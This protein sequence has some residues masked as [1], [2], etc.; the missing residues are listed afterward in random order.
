MGSIWVCFPIDS[1]WRRKE[2]NEMNVEHN[3]LKNC[4]LVIVFISRKEIMRI[5]QYNYEKCM[6]KDNR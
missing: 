1:S 6:E 2:E 3:G 4:T 5:L